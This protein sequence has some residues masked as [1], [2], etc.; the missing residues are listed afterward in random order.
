MVNLSSWRSFSEQVASESVIGMKD[1]S[2]SEVQV[3]DSMTKPD[4]N[5]KLLNLSI[6]S[7]LHRLDPH[8]LF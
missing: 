3:K 1:D 8:N 5:L 4:G 6:H 2:D 7:L